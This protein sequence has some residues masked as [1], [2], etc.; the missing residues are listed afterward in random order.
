MKL[1]G[2]AAA[3]PGLIIPRPSCVIVTD[4]ALPP[5]VLPFTVKG[6]LTQVWFELPFKVTV[7][8]L[9]QPQSTLTLVIIDSHKVTLSCT[10]TVCG[11]LATP[12]N[13]LET[14]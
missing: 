10:L 1:K 8:G 7:G 12:L 6:L 2:E 3:L 4:V 13:T 5:K 14:W 9:A 11:P